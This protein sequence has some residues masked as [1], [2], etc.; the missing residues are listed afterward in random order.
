MQRTLTMCN[1]RNRLWFSI[2]FVL[3]LVFCVNLS[4][5]QNPVRYVLNEIPLAETN[6]LSLGAMNSSGIVIGYHFPSGRHT[7][8]IY[9]H[10]GLLGDPRQTY[11]VTQWVPL[12]EGYNRSNC[13]GI[14]EWGQVVGSLSRTVHIDGSEEIV[15]SVGFLL[16]LD[17]FSEAPEPSWCFLPSAPGTLRSY[18]RRI[19][20]V[21]LVVIESMQPRAEYL[22]DSLDP[23]SELIPILDPATGERINSPNLSRVVRINDWGQ[24]SGIAAGNPNGG[25]GFLFTP[26]VNGAPGTIV[27]APYRTV[28]S[29]VNNSGQMCGN[30]WFVTPNGGSVSLR[31]AIRFTVENGIEVLSTEY[32]VVGHIN[33][34]GD[35]AGGFGKEGYQEHRPALYH[36]DLGWILLEGSLIDGAASDLSI[37][38]NSNSYRRM[39]AMANRNETGFPCLVARAFLSTT[40]TT[41]KGKNASTTTTTVSKYYFME[42]T[43]AGGGGDPPPPNQLTVPW[44]NYGL[45]GNGKHLLVTIPIRSDGDPVAGAVV[46][47]DLYRDGDFYRAFSGTTGSGGSVTFT[48][49]N[50]PSG[51]YETEITGVSKDGYTWDGE[52]PSNGYTK[53]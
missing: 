53:E 25:D 26:G 15:E 44:V 9:D 41:G 20:N 32:S 11:D 51:F 30:Q 18:G 6:Q 47:I 34:S 46:E 5:A 23:T 35:V 28:L 52:T 43:E 37:W 21:G 22:F 49:N 39:V 10:Y 27:W 48:Q 1:P 36:D 3:N 13:N 16:D 42:A 17:L 45:G 12:P 14:N 38:S 24:M 40:T 29:R 33:D 8:F 19:N 31:N 4:L 2:G 7:G 50:A